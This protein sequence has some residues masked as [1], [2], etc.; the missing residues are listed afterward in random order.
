MH[1]NLGLLS[2][3]SKCNQHGKQAAMDAGNFTNSRHTVGSFLVSSAGMG[4]G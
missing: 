4:E 2:T 1:A 3:L